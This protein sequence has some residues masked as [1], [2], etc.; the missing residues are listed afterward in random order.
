MCVGGVIYHT[1]ARVENTSFHFREHQTPPQP[2][3]LQ[4]VAVGVRLSIGSTPV[5]ACCC[6]RT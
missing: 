6:Y 1:T 2:Q 4:H 5:L 3:R